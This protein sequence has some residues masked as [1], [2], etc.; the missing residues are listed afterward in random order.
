MRS[1]TGPRSTRV[2]GSTTPPT[3]R[4]SQHERSADDRAR[5]ANQQVPN[6]EPPPRDRDRRP[7]AR[8]GVGA[9]FGAVDKG[10]EFRQIGRLERGIIRDLQRCHLT[11]VAR[12]VTLM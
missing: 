6:R 2:A 3:A 12:T 7:R 5:A 9:A 11:S 10:I 4:G 8:L 1:T